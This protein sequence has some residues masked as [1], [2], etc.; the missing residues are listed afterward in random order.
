MSIQKKLEI[1]KSLSWIL[2]AKTKPN[3]KKLTVS[4]EL[5]LYLFN[6]WKQLASPLVVSAKSLTP[7]ESSVNAFIKKVDSQMGQFGGNVKKRVQDDVEYLYKYSKKYYAEDKL[8]KISKAKKPKVG[9]EFWFPRD[10]EAIEALQKQLS[11][12]TGQFYTNQV[13][14]ALA[15][16]IK[17]NVFE[18]GLTGD[19]LTEAVMND[20]AVILRLKPSDLIGEVVPEGFHGTADLYFEGLADYS[21]T[22]TRSSAMMYGLDDVGAEKYVIRSLQTDRTCEGCLEMDGTEFTVESGV[23]H[24]ENMLSVD[25][26]DELK[27]VQPFFSFGTP[28]NNTE[29]Q[30]A[31]LK[32]LT[33]NVSFPPF[34][35]NCECY[36]DMA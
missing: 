30:L 33:S 35:Y 2:N 8:Q 9:G 15:E 32:G 24:L 1:L 31:N 19:E 17:E 7:S 10:E 5:S 27:K 4:K 23:E 6:E 36:I 26:L 16:S 12:T 29:A 21:S 34:H 28:G 11:E 13:Q 18:S 14:T 20:M 22:L 3:P 25:S